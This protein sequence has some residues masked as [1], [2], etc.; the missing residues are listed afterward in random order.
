MLKINENFSSFKEFYVL[1]EG[2]GSSIIEKFNELKKEI[3]TKDLDGNPINTKKIK[4]LEQEIFELL[5]A[6]G[7]L[8]K[9]VLKR[10]A[11]MIIGDPI[12]TINK[13]VGGLRIGFWLAAIAHLL[14][15]YGLKGF[16][17]IKDKRRAEDSPK[18]PP[19]V[20]NQNPTL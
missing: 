11:Y 3:M 1:E 20:Q 5:K 18:Q 9:D 4:S 17:D 12:I 10:F 19:I 2:I 13:K 8:N 16:H 7:R 15:I 6:L 14:A